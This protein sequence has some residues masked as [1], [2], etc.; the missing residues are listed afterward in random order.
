M[1]IYWVGP[2]WCRTQRSARNK[3]RRNRTYWRGC[4][5]S[6]GGMARWPAGYGMAAYFLGAAV[7]V[8]VMLFLGAQWPVKP[9]STD[10]RGVDRVP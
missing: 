5:P 3:G 1:L 8:C 4:W 7:G 6:V 2:S 10:S 9:R